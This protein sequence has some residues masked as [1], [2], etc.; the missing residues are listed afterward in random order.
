MIKDPGQPSGQPSPR[1]LAGT[2]RH[3]GALSAQVDATN[4]LAGGLSD[5]YGMQEVR[6]S[7]PLAPLSG[8]S[9]RSGACCHPAFVLSPGHD[10][11]IFPVTLCYTRWPVACAER[12]RA[13]QS[14]PA[15]PGRGSSC[16]CSSGSK[17]RRGG[18][19]PSAA[20]GLRGAKPGAHCSGGK[21][22]GSRRNPVWP[23]T[24]G[25]CGSTEHAPHEKGSAVTWHGQVSM[26][27]PATSATTVITNQSVNHMNRGTWAM[28]RRVAASEAL[29]PWLRTWATPD[30]SNNQ[31][32][33]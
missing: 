25:I 20:N 9:T 14:L 3:T 13:V 5:L 19:V 29:V 23:V 31:L 8:C 28:S 1:T 16:S 21:D 27:A 6:G 18:R 2:H 22:V 7:N 10:L 15:Q 30:K 33:Q 32:R 4:A 24:V 12:L 11:A 17:W 26:R